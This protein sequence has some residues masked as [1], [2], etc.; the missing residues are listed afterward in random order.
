MT[1]IRVRYRA[2]AVATRIRRTKKIEKVQA[3]IPDAGMML[4]PK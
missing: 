4:C 1:G 3:R 2:N